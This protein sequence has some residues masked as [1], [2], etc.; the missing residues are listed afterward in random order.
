MTISLKVVIGAVCSLFGSAMLGYLAW[1]GSVAVSHAERLS[2]LEA[3]DE[4]VW[5]WFNGIIE[6]LPHP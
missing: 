3:K 5:I 4:T 2:K 1:L 6:K